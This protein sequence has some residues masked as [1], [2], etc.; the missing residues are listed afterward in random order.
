MKQIERVTRP[1]SRNSA[2]FVG[3][4]SHWPRTWGATPG[5]TTG[6]PSLTT[7]RS[8]DAISGKKIMKWSLFQASGRNN[9]TKV[10]YL[11]R[12]EVFTGLSHV[13][14]KNGAK[15]GP[16]LRNCTWLFGKSTKGISVLFL[17]KLFVTIFFERQ[18]WEL[19]FE[20]LSVLKLPHHL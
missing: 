3:G 6:T 1:E 9:Q 5:N 11:G 15:P 12:S 14:F 13:E 19:E 16:R 18:L 2:R 17:E 10:R 8:K 20:C 7:A 4:V